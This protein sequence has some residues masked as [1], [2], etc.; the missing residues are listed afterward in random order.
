MIRLGFRYIWSKLA[1]V[2]VRKKLDGGDE[3]QNVICINGYSWESA[4][5]I[6]L[7]SMNLNLKL[8]LKNVGLVEQNWQVIFFMSFV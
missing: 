7:G 4:M 8:K 1:K 3:V 5:N 2:R 6:K